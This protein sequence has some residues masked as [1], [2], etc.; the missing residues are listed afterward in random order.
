MKF[1]GTVKGEWYQVTGDIFSST[2]DFICFDFQ[3]LGKV[4]Y[5]ACVDG[6]A[7]E[8]EDGCWSI[9]KEDG[10]TLTPMTETQKVEYLPQYQTNKLGWCRTEVRGYYIFVT[11]IGNRKVEYS[12]YISENTY[13]EDIVRYWDID[14]EQYACPLT[15]DEIEEFIIPYLTKDKGLHV[16][17]ASFI[18]DENDQDSICDMCER[19]LDTNRGTCEGSKCEQAKEMFYEEIDANIDHALKIYKP[20]MLVENLYTHE[21]PFTVEL[22][23]LIQADGQDLYVEK[24]GKKLWLFE[25]GVW[26]EIIETPNLVMTGLPDAHVENLHDSIKEFLVDTTSIASYDPS[27]F[28]PVEGPSMGY[29]SD[30]QKAGLKG[31]QRVPTM[32]GGK[33]VINVD[34]LR[35]QAKKMNLLPIDS[36]RVA[37][38]HNP[39]ISLYD[40]LNWMLPTDKKRGSEII[41][42]F[43]RK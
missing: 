12:K 7:F 11:G 24:S 2:S 13:Y 8:K 33:G 1:E 21:P 28:V 30:T 35:D 4:H 38:M 29:L 16:P 39:P 36:E 20:G 27:I 34:E 18:Y 31:Q 5:T 41:E 26:A 25:G 17:E 37:G 3:K 15:E 22:G 42:I 32:L 14:Y 43:I 40:G 6:G 19:N 10:D 23:D 9:C